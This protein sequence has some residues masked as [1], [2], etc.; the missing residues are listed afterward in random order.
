LAKAELREALFRAAAST[1]IRN[2]DVAAAVRAIL[3]PGDA[4]LD[5]GCGEYGLAPYIRDVPVVGVDITNSRF[6]GRNFRFV[7]G[8]ITALPFPD[9]SFAVAASVDTIEHLPTDVRTKAL[10]E[11]VRV[12]TEGVVVSFPR[13]VDARAIDQA[14]RDALASRKASEP[15]W[16]REHLEQAYPDVQ[17]TSRAIADA[18]KKL[19]RTPVMSVRYSE[20]DTCA[21]LTRAVSA[22]SARLGLI[23]DLMLGA[24]APLIPRP[25]AERSYRAI[26]VARFV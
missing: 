1:R 21:R 15:D 12:A 3:G 25:P 18:A 22:R 6:T 7:P 13:G 23:V 4:L 5:A 11:L 24:F 20:W 19:G 26:M 8:S 9:K 16:L 2:R 17:F 10:N 14:Y